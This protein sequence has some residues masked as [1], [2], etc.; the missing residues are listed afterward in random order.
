[1]AVNL[2]PVG[3]VAAQFFD[4]NGKPL[5]GGKLF[6]YAAGSTTPAATFTS[7]LGITAHTNPIVL[8]A[9]GR[10]PG[11]E[12]WLTDGIIYKFVLQTS[13]NVL[14]A[15]YDNIVGI[16]SNFVNFTLSQEI[17]TATAGQTVFNLNT[18]Q[19]QPGTNSLSVFVDGVNQ[20]GPGAQFAYVETDA[21]TVTFVSGLHVGASVKFTTA[22]QTTGNATDASV[23]AYTPAGVGAV[24]TTVQTKLRE[25]V[26][27]FDFMTSA[28]IADVQSKTSSIDV[29]AEIQAALDYVKITRQALHVPAGRYLITQI[30]IPSG[31]HVFGDGIGGYGSQLSTYPFDA[32]VF[33]QDSGVNDD[34]IVF[35]CPLESGF[36][37]LFHINLHDFIVLKKGTSDTIGNGIS[38]RQVGTDRTLNASHCLVNGV[39]VFERLLVRAFPENGMY[40]RQGAVP[41]YCNELDFIFNKGYGLRIDGLNYARNIV[42]RNIAGD[43]NT[44][45]ACVYIASPSVDAQVTVDGLY[46]EYRSDCPY[47][48]SA[49]FN[50]AQPYALELGSFGDNASVYVA[51]ALQESIVTNEAAAGLIFLTCAS[52]AQTPKITFDCLVMADLNAPSGQKRTLIDNRSWDSFNQFTIPATVTSGAYSL[53]NSGN[54]SSLQFTNGHT[55]FGTG[56]QKPLVSSEG[57]QVYGPLPT[58]SW[59]ESDAAADAKGWSVGPSSGSLIFRVFNDNGTAGENFL[60]VA[61]TGATVDY[62]EPLKK[63][64]LTNTPTFANNAA[65]IAGGLGVNDVYKTSTGELRIVV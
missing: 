6:T 31:A 18:M 32:T 58:Y 3:G 43:G 16:N 5:S 33:F 48:N 21:T 30:A 8:D 27:V 14:I 15:T 1:M 41:M 47:G 50:G 20:Y 9:A 38:A 23:V 46:S 57:V 37:R 63:L 12:I 28:Q 7:S 17:Q 35:D 52:Q 34:A 10:V 24:Q 53:V 19:Y 42:L 65:A 54:T 11:G 60:Q 4:N 64:R 62:I 56:F 44:G 59:Y 49:G 29:T 51:N 61:R 36:Y 45:R 2:S 13:T 26:S 40:F 55:T 22:A 39:A 25:T